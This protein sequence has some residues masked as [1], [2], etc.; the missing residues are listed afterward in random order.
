MKV[1]LSLAGLCKDFEAGV[2]RRARTRVLH[3]VDLDVRQGETLGIVGESGCG[4][5]T[6]AR[7]A[8]LSIAPTSGRIEFEGESLTELPHN[9]L[10]TRRRG[11]QMVFQNAGASLDPRFTVRRILSQPFRAAGNPLREDWLQEIL[12]LMSLDPQ[13]LERR[14]LSLSGG[15]QQR[16]AIARALMLEPRLLFA[17][18]P[19]SA[20][21]ASVQGQVLNLL[22]DLQH[23]LGLTLVL[24]SHSLPVVRHAA[25]RV[26]VMLLGRIVEEASAEQ[27]FRSPRHPYARMLLHCASGG[28]PPAGGERQTPGPGRG[29]VFHTR[30][31]EA[32]GRCREAA[33]SLASCGGGAKVACFLYDRP[34]GCA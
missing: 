6:L 10:R 7:C 18:E 17:D 15:E 27:F 12:R 14:P 11:F 8:T 32:F 31:P 19:V 29:C 34:G 3:D 21:D 9:E 20:L 1:L 4:K 5:T 33:P 16:V 2:V 30:C 23:R 13:V 28:R 22:S 24:I 26:A 25:Q